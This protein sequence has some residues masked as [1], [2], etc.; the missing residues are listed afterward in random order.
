ML[1]FS[2]PSQARQLMSNTLTLSSVSKGCSSYRDWKGFSKEN[3]L[4]WGENGLRIQ[5]WQSPRP[6][7]VVQT[8]MVMWR[9]I[10]EFATFQKQNKLDLVGQRL[11]GTNV[12]Y[13]VS[14]T[15]LPATWGAHFP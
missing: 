4:E 10:M 3:T 12:R 5:A 15:L 11:E 9:D 7:G 2:F 6:N 8:M 13:V 14:P 1:S